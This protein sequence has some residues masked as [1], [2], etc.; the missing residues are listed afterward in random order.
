MSISVC[1]I[2]NDGDSDLL[3]AGENKVAWYEN[4]YGQGLFGSPHNISLSVNNAY[5]VCSA[6]LDGD[7][8]QDVLSGS[9]FD[10]KLAWYN[11]TD[12]KGNF[13]LAIILAD[14]LTHVN[15]IRLEDIDNDID[16]ILTYAG[17]S[18]H[19]TGI[20][21]FENLDG[22][23][24]FSNG[25]LIVE[26]NNNFSTEFFELTDFDSDNDIDIVYYFPGKVVCYKNM[27][28]G[29]FW[30]NEN[31]IYSSNY[32]LTGA[33]SDL[34]NDN[35]LDILV[36][37]W[38]KIVWLENIDGNGNFSQATTITASVT[39]VRSVCAADLDCDGDIDIVSAS[40]EDN[41]IAWYENL[42]GT[43]NFSSQ[44]IISNTLIRTAFVG[45]ADFDND[46]DVDL[47]IGSDGTNSPPYLPGKILIYKN[48]TNPTSVQ[49]NQTDL[50][51][52]FQ[53]Y[54]NYP[55]PFNPS[56]IIRY[57]LP[58]AGQVTFEIYN[59]LGQKIEILVNE[60]QTSGKHQLQW[61]PEGLSSGIYIVQLRAGSQ[62]K[63]M[64]LV[65]QK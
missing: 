26:I 51:N 35:D 5:A 58:Q 15:C 31:I 56:T 19:K 48:L 55:N 22:C 6:D 2:D 44:N 53:L 32:I 27:D 25:Q 38:D 17:S 1:D 42:N 36:A 28:L 13:S 45:G 40:M 64:K 37:Q 52:T 39:D 49:E 7:G 57:S 47:V 62:S 34:D 63:S 41:K 10:S 33:L 18:S 9:L 65:L 8:D 46:G 23:G 3:S 54:Q 16:I 29:K 59:L 43:G 30:G 20:Y 24:A 4:T 50:P 60:Y 14:S 61:K 11:N 12:G 21:L